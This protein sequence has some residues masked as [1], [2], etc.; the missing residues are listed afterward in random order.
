MTSESGSS[1]KQPASREQN[2]AVKAWCEPVVIPTYPVPPPDPNPMFLEKRVY[3]GSSGKVYPNPFTDRVSDE[4]VDK[5]YQAIHLENEYLYLMILPELGGRIHIAYDKANDYDFFYRNNVI[6]PALVGLLGPWISGGVEF[7]WPQHHRPSTFMPVDYHI[8]SHADGSRTIWLSEHEPMNRMK[9]MVGICLHPGKAFIEAKVRLFNRT[10]FVQTFLWWANVAVHVHD[11]YQAFFPPDVSYVADHAK[12][13]VSHY[14]IARGFYYGV[15]YTSGV[16]ISWYRNIPV[17]TSYM[18]P[19]SQYDFFGGYDYG[20]RAGVVHVADHHISPGKKLWTWGNAE[21]GCAWD[22]EL[23]DTDGPYIELM[24]GVYTDNQPDFSWLHPYETKTFEQ[25][26]YPIREIGPAKNAN[27]RA[28]VNLEIEDK[29]VK[30]GASVTEPFM[31]ATVSLTVSGES[32]L[33]R[34]VDLAPD[35]P[36]VEETSLSDEIEGT[37]CLLRVLTEQGDELIRYAPEETGET[38]VP[39][40][41]TEPPLPP[42]IGTTEELYLTGL[43]LE[44]YRH[45]TR[46]AEDY[47]EEALRREP[48]DA[49]SNNALGLLH[50]RRGEFERAEKHFRRAIETLTRLNPN[51]YDGE[52]YYNLGLALK[53]QDRLDEAYDVF[54]KAIWNYAWRAPAY[55]TLAEISCRH[56]DKDM[57]LGHLERV[58]LTDAD[59]LKARNLKT[60]VLRRSGRYEK[61]EALAWQTAAT[62]TLDFWAHNELALISRETR[63]FAATANKLRQLGDLMRGEVQTYLDLAF[64]YAGAGL[65]EEATELLQRLL[66]DDREE[67][68]VYPM[69]YYALSSFAEQLGKAEEAKTYRQQGARMPPNYCFPARLEEAQILRSAQEA[70]PDDARAFYYLGN[71]LYDKKCYEEAINNWETSCQLEPGFSIPWR[72]LGIAYFNVRK[73]SEKA[74]EC[75]LK[76]FGVNPEDARL[77]FEL[78]QLMKRLGSAPA[79]RLAKL[80]EHLD[81]VEQRDDL[82]VEYIMLSNQ[83]RK[84]A[85]ALEL[86]S[87]RRFHPWEGGEGKVS[88]QYVNAHILSGRKA[89]EAGDGENALTHFEAAQSYP[90]N[91]GEG[92]HLLTPEADLHY[93]AGL[94]RKALGD[95]K[96]SKTCFR[97]AAGTG[98]PPY[99]IAYYQALA[100]KELGQEVASVQK[101]EE[102]LAFAEKQMQSEVKIEYFA[103]SLPNFLIFEDD[104]RRRNRVDCTFLKGLAY[105]GLGQTFEAEKAFRDVLAVDG[106]HL[107]AQEELDI[108]TRRDERDDGSAS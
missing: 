42:K 61:A 16:D 74:K 71:L 51:T 96:G 44:Q 54:Y 11:Q 89:L 90:E 38:P 64:D 81:L 59:N 25:Y 15:D 48:G 100:L 93:F 99:R 8:E 70:S 82:Y 28:A 77:L 37:D 60:A 56:G 58:L 105:L 76:A 14:P 57:A 101:L 40:P 17:P 98:P 24:A 75:Y 53:F 78:D 50:L 12:R 10:P 43:H 34:M 30:L 88:S 83:M 67:V 92:K 33:D 41:A 102:L 21:F 87:A 69:V 47:W 31:H 35:R 36:F 97:K 94:A 63:N 29:L 80:E 5:S 39:E 79:E 3:Q 7:N 84:P 107:W 106:N 20:R 9:G 66:P 13:A 85:T 49:R 73:D 86:L 45:A 27:R 4:K 103:T 91:L 32:L 65:W 23:T 2:G 62:D 95:E 18:V 26:W 55:Y 1:A 104:L 6:K 46:Y 52:P 22:R 68:V 72:N 108:L 19:E